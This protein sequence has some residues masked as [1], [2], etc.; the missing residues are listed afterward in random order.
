MLLTELTPVY[1]DQIIRLGKQLHTESRFKDEPFDEVRCRK[2]LINTLAFP[3]RVF[4]AFNV[5]DDTVTSFA[6]LGI[7]EHFFS[8]VLLASDYGVYVAPEYRGSGQFIR[9][10]KASEQWAQDCGAK[11]LTIYHNTG[12]QTDKAP[13]LFNKLGFSMNGYIFS[14]EIEECV[15]ES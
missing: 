4:C 7:Q 6:L 14:K 11:S 15:V 1:A 13:V 10:V 5:V 2:I 12:I 9:L 3:N 8:G